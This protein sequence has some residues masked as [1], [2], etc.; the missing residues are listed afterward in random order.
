MSA[1]VRP[2]R[3][4]GRAAG[5]ALAAAFGA[6]TAR[7]LV[8]LIR[9]AA[10][11]S[12]ATRRRVAWAFGTLA[13][14]LVRRR[15]RIAA[16]NLRACFP[17]LPAAQRR[18]IARRL[19]RN[20]ARGAL[21][22]G[23]LWT[24]PREGVCAFVRTEGLEHLS[25]PANYPLIMLAPHFVGLDAGG[26][27]L[28]I[29]RKSVTIY[30]RQ[31][32][33]VWDHW[34]QYGRARFNEPVLIARRG[35]DL[36][37]ALRALRAGLPFYY[38]PD[39]DSGDANSIFVPFFGIAAATLPMVSRLARSIGAKVV[40]T[41]TEQTPDGYVLHVEPPWEGFPGASIEEDTARMNREI[42]RWVRRMPDQ[43][44]WTHRRFKTRPPG[45]ASIYL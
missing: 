30:A 34:L 24:A 19:F 33:P 2:R 4:I 40:M 43:Y 42:E 18:A 41:V 7:V 27:R 5:G 38:L 39:V 6:A 17:E 10:R 37:A 15:R 9:R 36:R 22:Y 12:P 32:N 44:L 1:A 23:V 26:S 25:E 28:A 14:L 11:W 16:A 13:W 29:E 21:D 45:H 3:A 20:I 8:V 35:A 31:S